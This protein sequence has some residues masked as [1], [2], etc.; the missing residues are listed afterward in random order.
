MNGARPEI[1]LL[2]E[3]AGESPPHWSEARI[4][5]VVMGSGIVIVGLVVAVILGGTMQTAY[6]PVE[7]PVPSSSS[8]ALATSVRRSIE[9][10]ILEADD[11][12]EPLVISLVDPAPK[13]LTGGLASFN[14][15]VCVSATSA[16][17][18]SDRVKVSLDG[19]LLRAAYYGDV[20]SPV[21]VRLDPEFPN[22]ALLGKG[23]CVSGYVTFPYVAANGPHVIAYVSNR[24]EWSWYLG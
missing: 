1:E 17:V 22:E 8:R 9:Q 24:F 3:W 21:V 7:P 11:P 18:A 5:R 6:G 13:L 4:A 20:S 10:P 15:K 2:D 12:A 23:Q 16:G 19:W 14:V